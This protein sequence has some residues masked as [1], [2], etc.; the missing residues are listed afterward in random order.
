MTTDCMMNEN[1]LGSIPG[2]IK[3]LQ[4]MDIFAENF[5]VITHAQL[6]EE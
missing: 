6:V 1:M 3:I 5:I 2:S 4:N